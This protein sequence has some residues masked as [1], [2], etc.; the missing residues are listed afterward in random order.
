[1]KHRWKLP[2]VIFCREE[3]HIFKTLGIFISRLL[4]GRLDEA[5]VNSLRRSY[6][7]QIQHKNTELASLLK[8]Q[9]EMDGEIAEISDSHFGL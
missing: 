1:M 6:E 2:A 5:E 3:E 7:D 8:R 4:N 9:E